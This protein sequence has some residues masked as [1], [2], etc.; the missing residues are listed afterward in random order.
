MTA[1]Q[2]N[3][4][5]KDVDMLVTASTILESAIANK[6]FLQT[7]RSTWTDAFFDDLK[8]K[9]ENAIQTYLGI[10]SA[11]DLRQATQAL[12]DIQTKAI[13]DLAEAKIQITEDFKSDKTR[14]EEL[15]KQLGFTS[16]HKDAQKGDQEALINLLFQFKTNLTD[17]LKDE[18]VNKG[19][20]KALLDAITGYADTLKNADVTQENY[21]GTKKTITAGALKEFNEIYDSVISICKIAGK[22]Y[23]DKPHLKDQFSYNKVAKTL[24]AKAKAATPAAPVT[25]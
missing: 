3:Y 4:K 8:A 13:K 1:A 16:Y 7:K 24:N 20:A 21:K 6:T 22:F 12:T 11:K 23:N 19:T 15:L 14:R 25:P 9:V 17:T 2:R 10:D 5:T 18:I